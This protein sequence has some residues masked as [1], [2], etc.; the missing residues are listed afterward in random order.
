MSKPWAVL[1]FGGSSVGEAKH[2]QT[3]YNQVCEQINQGRRVVLVLSALKNISNVLEGL[4]H[5]AKAGVHPFAIE[6]LKQHHLS[7]AAQM[8]IEA[9]SML[10]PWFD[11]L[12]GICQSIADSKLI[13]PEHHAAVLA[14]GELLS[15]TLGAIYLQQKE[16]KAKWLDIRSSLSVNDL[17]QTDSWHHFT[18]NEANL[19][20]CT[21]RQ[22][23]DDI[24]CDLI[25]T[26]GFIASDHHNKTVLLGREGSDTTAAYVGHLLNAD[27]VQIWTDVPGVFTY[28]PRALSQA[29]QIKNLSYQQA[30]LLA[31]AGARVLHPRALAP[32]AQKQVPIEVKSTSIPNMA[33][34]MINGNPTATNSVIAFAL[35]ELVT[36]VC[37]ESLRAN[38]VVLQKMPPIGFDLINQEKAEQNFSF[39]RYSNSDSPKPESSKLREL[40]LIEPL[41]VEELSLVSVIGAKNQPTW[42]SEVLAL[43]KTQFDVKYCFTNV[44]DGVVKFLL[45]SQQGKLMVEDLHNQ[46]I[47]QTKQ[48]DPS[49]SFGQSWQEI[50][51]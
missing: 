18:S 42:Q 20:E 25:V 48:T 22:K 45:E 5:Q 32:L 51:N 1:K 28:N 2:W 21:L 8:G 26:Q 9:D 36:V 15:S 46:F 39:W 41:N 50:V 4:L 23:L 10:T 38:D 12:N 6:H 19:S 43:A 47:P 13:S 14:M 16:L 40:L 11:E 35:E 17:S 3:I 31:N 24:D 29:R 49:M 37:T 7:F 44:D 33:G 34:S 30:F 27:L